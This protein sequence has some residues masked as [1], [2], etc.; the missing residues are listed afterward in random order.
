MQIDKPEAIVPTMVIFSFM[1]FLPISVTF[2]SKLDTS[3]LNFSSIVIPPWGI[4][5]KT[6]QYGIE[7]HVVCILLASRNE[8]RLDYTTAEY[9][10]Q[11]RLW[12]I[13]QEWFWDV[14]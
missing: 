4:E 6:W 14:K 5:I 9:E 7:S 8:R 3:A 10:S 13:A 11:R 2:F 12:L 1:A